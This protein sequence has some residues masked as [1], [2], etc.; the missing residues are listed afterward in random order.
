MC[1]EWEGDIEEYVVLCWDLVWSHLLH[2]RAK[3]GEDTPHHLRL[4]Y[5]DGDIGWRVLIHGLS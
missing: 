5:G 3:W 1:K 2:Y 4:G